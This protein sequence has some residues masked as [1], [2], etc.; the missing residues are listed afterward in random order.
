MNRDFA[1]M[2]VRQLP[3]GVATTAKANATK[4]AKP[5]AKKTAKKT[6]AKR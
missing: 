5:A 2:V 3:T 6:S 1:A 4:A